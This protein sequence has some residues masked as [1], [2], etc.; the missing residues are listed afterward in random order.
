MDSA[1]ISEHHEQ[2]AYIHGYILADRLDDR[3]LRTHIIEHLIDTCSD[4][5]SVPGGEWCTVI[6]EQTPAG[7]PLRT[8]I[9][10]YIWEYLNPGQ[11][12]EMVPNMPKEF[13]EEYAMHAQF[14]KEFRWEL[15]F[16]ERLRNALLPE[17][18]AGSYQNKMREIILGARERWRARAEAE[19]QAQA[20][21]EAGAEE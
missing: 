14:A 4:W 11:F 15:S 17:G 3:E 20:G 13:L 2:F 8:L 1:D 5:E 9:M 6:W 19:A 12:I 7:S 10:L 16:Q 21:G 18:N